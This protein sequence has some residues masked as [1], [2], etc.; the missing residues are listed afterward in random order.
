MDLTRSYRSGI[1]SEFFFQAVRNCDDL[2]TAGV[3]T[4]LKQTPLGWARDEERLLYTRQYELEER[5]LTVCLATLAEANFH[6]AFEMR[7]I[8]NYKVAIAAHD[9]ASLSLRT[10]E[11]A[12]QFRCAMEIRLRTCLAERRNLAADER[13]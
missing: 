8:I 12:A 10:P 11:V 5:R 6:F 2:H 3:F 4:W 7:L 13:R 9:L 1:I